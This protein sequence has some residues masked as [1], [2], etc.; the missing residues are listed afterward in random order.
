MTNL[1]VTTVFAGLNW[2]R[3]GQLFMTTMIMVNCLAATLTAS[4]CTAA[5]FDGS[6]MQG[7]PYE[8]PLLGMLVVYAVTLFLVAG[9]MLDMFFIQLVGEQE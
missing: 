5:F 4:L 9:A 8:W 6:N 7:V 3:I 1:E 2:D